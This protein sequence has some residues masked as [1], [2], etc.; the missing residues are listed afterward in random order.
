MAVT[1]RIVASPHAFH[2]EYTSGKFASLRAL[3]GFLPLTCL[4]VVVFNHV[5]AAEGKRAVTRNTE[6]ML[7]LGQGTEFH[8]WLQ[9]E[10]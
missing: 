5:H 8:D 1:S 4:E 3:R 9:R 10:N 7:S 2:N 6:E